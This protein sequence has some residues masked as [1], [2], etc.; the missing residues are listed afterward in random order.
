[1]HNF[2]G[3]TFVRYG[4]VLITMRRRALH[5]INNKTPAVATDRL[6]CA[7]P[8]VC[9]ALYL[10]R[11]VYAP[12]SMWSTARFSQHRLLCGTNI[13]H[14]SAFREHFERSEECNGLAQRRYA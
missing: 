6:L 14:N 7:M 2:C 1:M 8:C 3:T 11:L 12:P 9:T 5:N 4:S 13:A 10:H